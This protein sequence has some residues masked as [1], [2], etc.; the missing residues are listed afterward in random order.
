VKACEA[1]IRAEWGDALR[2]LDEGALTPWALDEVNRRF[3]VEVGLPAQAT[4]GGN[5]VIRFFTASAFRAMTSA[6][7]PCI[8]TGETDTGALVLVETT[9]GHV[10]MGDETGWMFANASLEALLCCVAMY[11]REFIAFPLGLGDEG[12]PD[13]NDCPGTPVTRARAGQLRACLDALDP[14]ALDVAY[15]GNGVSL[16]GFVVEEVEAGVV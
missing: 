14:L 16:W 6:G 5:L 7:R 2:P 12:E 1:A 4:D 15:E 3:L 13:E 11:R 10:L 8:C 9:S